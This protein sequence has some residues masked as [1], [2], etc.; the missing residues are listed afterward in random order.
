MNEAYWQD[1]VVLVT[2]G[3]SGLGRV[4]AEQFAAAG[5]KI[6]VAALESNAAEQT[7]AQL[8]SAGRSALG[9]QADITRQDDV[10]RL[11][12]QVL[13]RYARLDVLVNNAGRS[14]RGKILGTTPEQ[15]RDLME[16]N[17]I[18]LVRCTRAAAPHL[19]AVRG[20]VVNM[21]SLASKSAARWVGAYPATKH[22]VAAYSQQLRLELGGQGLHVLLVC[23]GPVARSGA[24]LYPLQGLEEVPES[25]RAPGAGVHTRAIPPEQLARL[26]LR[27]CQRRQPELVLPGKAR[28]LFALSQLFPRLGDWLVLRKT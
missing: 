26:I 28:L 5:A 7:A 21:G 9:I 23:P 17:L 22:A 25:A 8:Q 10:D 4:I 3:S 13:D 12:A 6:A 16:L 2:G 1:K 27:A 11:F 15:F 18:A 19:L 14:M 20:H 24:R